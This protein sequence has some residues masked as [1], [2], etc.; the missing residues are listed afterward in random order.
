MLADT[1]QPVT[2]MAVRVEAGVHALTLLFLAVS[3][4]TVVNQVHA[5]GFW[6]G[7]QIMQEVHRRHRQ[8][9]YVYEEHSIIL[10]DRMGQRDTRQARLYTRVEDN[11]EIKI[12]YIFEAPADVKGVTLMAFRQPDGKTDTSIYLPAF[13]DRFINSSWTGSG[14]NFLGTDFSIE[15]LTDEVLDDYRYV[16][17]DDQKL[18]DQD[19]FVIDVYPSEGKLKDEHPVKRHY[20]R[21]DCFYIT[22]TDYFDRMGRLYKQMHAYDLK[23]LDDEMWGSNLIFMDDKK[24]HHQ[25]IIK[26]DRRVFSID[27]VPEEMFNKEWI[28]AAYPPLEQQQTADNTTGEGDNNGGKAGTGTLSPAAGESGGQEQ[29]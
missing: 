20:V 6:N 25:S 22:R 2:M 8:Y 15:D 4:A 24:L 3:L 18:G 16:R 5:A 13:S 11:G 28:L 19:Y 17:R 12:L 10:V 14:G 7:L 9:P 1:R 26:V 29:P 23:K 21:Q 27:Y